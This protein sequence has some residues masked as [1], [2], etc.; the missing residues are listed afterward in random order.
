VLFKDRLAQVLAHASRYQSSLAV[1]LLDLDRFKVS[2]DTLGHNVGD[3][4]LRQV[5]G[6]LSDSFRQSDSV[7]RYVDKK[8]ESFTRAI[9]RR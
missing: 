6:R 7:S 8:G 4:L 2:N 3:L 5:A 1:L 9:G